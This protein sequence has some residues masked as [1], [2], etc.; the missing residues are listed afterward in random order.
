MDIQNE[1]VI[2][3]QFS[4][5]D[6]E[7]LVC[8]NKYDCFVR[9][10]KLLA[11]QHSF[12]AICLKLIVKEMDGAWG[13]VCPMCRRTTAVL[14]AAVS[15]LPN[16]E[17]IMGLLSRRMSSFPESIPEI[18]LCPQLLLAGQDGNQLPTDHG[19]SETSQPS[20]SSASEGDAPS[21]STAAILKQ[22]MVVLVFFMVTLIIIN[23]FINHST[24]MWVIVALGVLSFILLVVLIHNWWQTGAVIQALEFCK[25]VC[26]NEEAE[27]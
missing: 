19:T 25:G 26:S 9:K 20:L 22:F 1:V 18:V 3:R 24:L 16:N 13:V 4:A 2:L 27:L 10:P 8:C 21:L 17:M 23:S 14:E 6:L 15:N 7:C 5:S 11:C 12:C